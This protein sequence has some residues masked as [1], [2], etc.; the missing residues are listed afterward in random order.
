MHKY[1]PRGALK[2]YKPKLSVI[3]ENK[4]S[5][6]QPVK[7]VVYSGKRKTSKDMIAPATGEFS[8]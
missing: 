3:D 6:F 4:I 1:Q 8:F 5:D 7:K 2:K